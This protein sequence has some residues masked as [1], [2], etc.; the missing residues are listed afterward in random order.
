MAL[1]AGR[2]GVRKDQVDVNGIIDMSN[3][4]TE[5]P[6]YSS[7]DEGKVLSVDSNG[8]L[9]FVTPETYILPTASSETL[10]GVKVGSGLS[11]TDGV[12]SSQGGASI[13]AVE[14]TASWPSQGCN[15][16]NCNANRPQ[17]GY[18]LI[19]VVWKDYASPGTDRQW[20]VCPYDDGTNCGFFLNG[21]IDRTNSSFDLIFAKF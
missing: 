8:D 10:G 13:V 18:K 7:S 12:L 17:G 6:S 15:S 4:P 19:S 9:E 3:V 16:K 5:L 21:N 1:K 14:V 11:I 2:V 20:S